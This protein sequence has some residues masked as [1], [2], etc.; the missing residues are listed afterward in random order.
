[1]PNST[2]LDE[3]GQAKCVVCKKVYG[4]GQLQDKCEFCG[5]WFCKDCAEDTPKPFGHGKICRKCFNKLSKDAEKFYG[6][7]S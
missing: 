7:K 2:D 3:F 1:M 5:K 6:G 4:L